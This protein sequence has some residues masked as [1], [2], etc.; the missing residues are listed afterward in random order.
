MVLHSLVNNRVPPCLTDH[1]IGPL[2]HDDGD[3]ESC[4][5][6]VFQHFTLGIG[7]S[8]EKVVSVNNK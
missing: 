7:L 1:Q 8:K 3:E 5:G 2:Y 4:V 6:G